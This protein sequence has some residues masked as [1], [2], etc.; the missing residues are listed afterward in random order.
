L[1]NL[2]TRGTTP[3]IES[4]TI[5]STPLYHLNGDDTG[6]AERMIRAGDGIEASGDRACA[7]CSD[8]STSLSGVETLSVCETI[9]SQPTVASASCTTMPGSRS[10]VRSGFE[11]EAKQNAQ[12][13][14]SVR[15]LGCPS[16]AKAKRL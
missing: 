2:E 15:G 5:E 7:A 10:G 11:D 3:L 12:I 1:E 16:K 4:D 8:N 6:T 13:E 14:A 9:S